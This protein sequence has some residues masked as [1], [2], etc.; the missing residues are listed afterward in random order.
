MREG[1]R[2]AVAAIDR[3]IGIFNALLRLVEIDSGLRRSGFRL[4]DLARIAGEVGEL[5]GPLAEEKQLDFAVEAGPGR[6]VDGDPYLLA[7]AIGN[8]VDNAVK[9]APPGGRVKLRVAAARDGRIDIAVADNGPG[10]ADSEK[11]RVTERFYRGGGASETA[12]LGLGLSVVD[13]V[14]RLHEGT[15]SLS[16]NDP[17]LVGSLSIPAA[18]MSTPPLPAA[19]PIGA[20]PPAV[21]A[22]DRSTAPTRGLESTAIS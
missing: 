14:A 10:I 7:Q 15:L 19:A 16:D 20:N 12:G 9:Y 18:A 22:S 4:V 13:A 17:G 21:D 2:G 6:V 1:V 8:L 3:V 11:P 5:Y